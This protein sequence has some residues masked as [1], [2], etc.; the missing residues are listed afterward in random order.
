MS[1]PRPLW[2]LRWKLVLSYVGVTLLTVLVLEVTVLVGMH[3]LGAG[4]I[5]AWMGRQER[6]ALELLAE[7]LASSLASDPTA[8]LS[9]QLA[10]S[11][12]LQ[13]TLATA[14]PETGAITMLENLRVAVA[15][16][17]A[18]L[19][20]TAADRFAK[21]SAF[22]DPDLPAAGRLVNRVLADGGI[23]TFL[24]VDRQY[25]ATVVPI[26]GSGSERLGAIYVRLPVPNVGA[27]RLGRVGGSIVTAT[28]CCC[29]CRS[30]S[31]W[32]WSSVSPRRC[33]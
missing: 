23:E 8:D 18:V 20:S 16:S 25:L 1:R 7:E 32:D 14:D 27:W 29:C 33:R 24:D 28:L 21:G 5:G 11:E 6:P 22:H 2:R 26:I 15:P 31:P 19:G 4:I 30:R 13:F 3:F 17:G 12:G 10:G 9:P